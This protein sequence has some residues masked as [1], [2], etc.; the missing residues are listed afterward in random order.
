M[1]TLVLGLGNAILCDD[2]V[3]LQVTR[4]LASRLDHQQEVTV[5]EANIAGL[6]ILDQLTGYEKAIIID[7]IQTKGGKAGQVYRLEPGVFDVT[8]HT[9]TSHN[10]NFATALELGR[11]LGLPLP[12][13][14]VIFGIEVANTNTFSEECTPEVERAIPHCVEMVLHELDDNS[15]I[16]A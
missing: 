15:N 10:V 2:S 5:I 6:D 4:A 7:A 16:R 12:R 3:G 14:I 13:Q 1:K 11:Q 9:T 8:R